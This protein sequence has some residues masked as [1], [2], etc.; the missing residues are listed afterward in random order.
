[1]AYMK[2]SAFKYENY[3]NSR[4]LW[5]AK[6]SALKKKWSVTHPQVFVFVKTS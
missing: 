3:P 4:N 6:P 2:I 1:M 5:K